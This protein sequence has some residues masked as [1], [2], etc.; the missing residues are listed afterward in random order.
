MTRISSG[1]I[2]AG[3]YADKLRRVMFAIAK[4]KADPKEIVRATG[5]L[6]STL[7]EVFR[8]IGIDKGD[9]V[10]ITIEF[11]I[12]NGTIEWKWDT[13]EIQHYRLVPETQEKAKEVLKKIL[14]KMKAP[15][16][17]IELKVEFHTAR[18]AEEVYVVKIKVGKEYTVSGVVGVEFIGETGRARA[19][20]ITPEGKALSYTFS[21]S[22][23]PDP[24]KVASDIEEILSKAYG[25]KAMREIDKEEAKKIL[26]ELLS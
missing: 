17:P 8:E 2:I 15:P 14:E 7:F 12:V 5:V 1:L 19:I 18:D 6:N 11:E 23:N 24:H 26:Q 3:A 20:I 4:E 10:R 9:V 22:Y 13:L 16:P 25:E 21:V